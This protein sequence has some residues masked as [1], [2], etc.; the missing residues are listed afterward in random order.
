MPQLAKPTHKKRAT[1]K[2]SEMFDEQ[3]AAELL[4]KAVVTGDRKSRSAIEA[5]NKK[6]MAEASVCAANIRNRGDD[7]HANGSGGTQGTRGSTT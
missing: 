7:V 5:A 3:W 4:R 6:K 2:P 1:M